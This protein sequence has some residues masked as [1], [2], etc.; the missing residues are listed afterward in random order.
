MD[1]ELKREIIIDN[2]QH[3]VHKGLVDDE[4]Y[5]KENTNNE[6]CIDHIDKLISVNI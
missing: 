4:A 2:Y 3:P 6:S 5:I 1:E